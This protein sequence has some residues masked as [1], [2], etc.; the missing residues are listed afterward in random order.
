MT[1]P[2]PESIRHFGRAAV[3]FVVAMLMLISSGLFQWPLVGLAGLVGIVFSIARMIYVLWVD[4]LAADTA[5]KAYNP[6]DEP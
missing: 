1:K 2:N 4:S 3:L 6:H 5:R